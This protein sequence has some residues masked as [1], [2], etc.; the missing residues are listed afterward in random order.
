M[1]SSQEGEPG[2]DDLDLEILSQ[3]QEDGRRPF[4]EIA[5]RLG[6]KSEG[7]V[8]NRVHRLLNE[9]I[10][11]I[12][13]VVNPQALGFNTQAFIGI[14]VDPPFIESAAEAFQKFEEVTYLAWSSGR[15]DLMIQ[16]VCRDNEHFVEFLSK[17]LN[18]VEGVRS[19]EVYMILRTYRQTANWAIS[20]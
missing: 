15:V 10:I 5:E 2:L 4:T 6:G 19:T 1:R 14:I 8:R 12:Q 11:S 20:R 18:Q 16:V 9:S 3:L 17:K 7:M 13:A